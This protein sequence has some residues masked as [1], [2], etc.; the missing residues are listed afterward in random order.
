MT[1]T[2]K[3]LDNDVM[4]ANCDVIVISPIYDQF[5]AIQKPDSGGTVCKTYIFVN[6][7]VLSCKN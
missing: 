7:N 3:K 6:T 1:A 4:L 5:Q 2:P